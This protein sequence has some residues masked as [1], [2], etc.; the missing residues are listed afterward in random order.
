MN[1]S[2]VWTGPAEGE[3][4]AVWLAAADRAAVTAGAA[5]VDAELARD[6]GEAG[7][8]RE[9]GVRVLLARPPGV[10]F[11]VAAESR[12]VYVFRAWGHR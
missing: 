8:S 4:A 6:G 1:S 7:E 9:P 2:V 5:R 3:L 12:T 11:T 10:L